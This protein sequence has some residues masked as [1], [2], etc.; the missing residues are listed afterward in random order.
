MGRGAATRTSRFTHDRRVLQGAI[1]SLQARA[2]TRARSASAPLRRFRL[3]PR[4]TY[5]KGRSCASAMS[6]RYVHGRQPL[7]RVGRGP[8]PWPCL[9]AYVA[10]VSREHPRTLKACRHEPLP[11][12][13]YTAPHTAGPAA[14]L[15]GQ[16]TCIPLQVEQEDAA[17]TQQIETLEWA[18]GIPA[19]EFFAQ[20]SRKFVRR[21]TPA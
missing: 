11:H 16:D 9:G 12:P 5:L 3:S 10:S 17:R 19:A 20:G 4:R 1:R 7:R 2:R 6:A 21:Y 15:T 18:Y 14:D 13:L 8:V